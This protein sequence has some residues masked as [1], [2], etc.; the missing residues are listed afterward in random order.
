MQTVRSDSYDCKFRT[1]YSATWAEN[2]YF[3]L[4]LVISHIIAWREASIL[5]LIHPYLISISILNV[6]FE[7]WSQQAQITVAYPPTISIGPMLYIAQ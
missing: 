1:E 3:A 5:W 4:V 2:E 6:P 7:F